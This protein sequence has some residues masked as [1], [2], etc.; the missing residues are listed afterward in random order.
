MQKV[1]YTCDAC[2]EEISDYE[3]THTRNVVTIK[4]AV[5]A[6]AVTY[7]VHGRCAEVVDNFLRFGVRAGRR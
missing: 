1:V 2:G 6:K 7:D 5:D 3:A 4:S